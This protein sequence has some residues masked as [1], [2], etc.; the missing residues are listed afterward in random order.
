MMA[1]LGIANNGLFC[2]TLLET[3]S[4]Y[5]TSTTYNKKR[6]ELSACGPF[7]DE[8]GLTPYVRVLAAQ[9][10]VQSKKAELRAMHEQLNPFALAREVE[11]QKKEIN[12]QRLLKS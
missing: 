5:G 3:E 1:E 2:T 9:E 4:D 7:T 6:P 10:V 8:L 11:R 12:R